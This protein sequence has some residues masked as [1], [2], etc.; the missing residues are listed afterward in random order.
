MG[1]N[2]NPTELKYDLKITE[3]L[4]ATFRA[5]KGDAWGNVEGKS[6]DIYWVRPS[7]RVVVRGSCKGLLV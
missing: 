2:G 7:C 1:H 3:S 6:K 5:E 4:R